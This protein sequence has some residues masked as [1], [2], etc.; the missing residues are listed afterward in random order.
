MLPSYRNQ[1]VNLLYKS[2]DWFLY[3][4]NIVKGLSQISKFVELISDRYSHFTPPENHSVQLTTQP[5]FK[6]S[7]LTIETLE[8]RE[9][10]SE[11]TIKTELCQWHR[12]GI[13]IVN[14]EHITCSIVFIVNFEQVREETSTYQL[15][16][17][18]AQLL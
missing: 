5:A 14:C 18:T 13:F 16:I 15:E 3:D 1:S 7:K 4:G 8:Q 10:C 6:F 9:I 2:T 17:L 12:S 11:L